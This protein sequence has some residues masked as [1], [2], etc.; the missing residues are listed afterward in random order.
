MTAE[1]ALLEQTRLLIERLERISVDSV[2]ARR[3]SGHRGALLKWIQRLESPD[4]QVH[5]E[6]SKK[7]LQV[8]E[9]LIGTGFQFLEKAA[10]DRFL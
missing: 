3:S 4:G 8:L 1:Q 5:V 6:L 10:R 9:T 7:E 2:W